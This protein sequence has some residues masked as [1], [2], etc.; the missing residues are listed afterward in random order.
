MRTIQRE[1]IQDALK[2][3]SLN[4]NFRIYDEYGSWKCVAVELISVSRIFR[5][6]VALGAVDEGWPTVTGVYD[7]AESARIFA[8]GRPTVYFPGWQLED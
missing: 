6:L 1:M 5:F 2:E 7:M 4:D 8:E 3:A